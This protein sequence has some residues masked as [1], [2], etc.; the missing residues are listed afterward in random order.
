MTANKWDVWLANVP[1]EEGI[2]SKIR[3]VLIIDP[4]HYYV[5][6]CK[7]M[8]HE[9]RCGFPYEYLLQDWSGAG[10]SRP[11]TLRLSKRPRLEADR[12]IKKLGVI[13]PID[14]VQIY[15]MLNEIANSEGREG[16]S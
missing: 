11:T 4:Q 14:L 3:P 15:A 8:T 12:L 1:F 13:Q 7:M 10:L 6:V 9:P 5:I 16:Q 2:G